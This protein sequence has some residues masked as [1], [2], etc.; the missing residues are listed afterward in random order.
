MTISHSL[1]KDEAIRRLKPAL[2]RA[3]QSFP[4]FKIEHEVWS[5]NRVN[6][7]V[8]AIG[9]VVAGNVQAFDNRVRLEVSLPGCS[10]NLRTRDD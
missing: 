1:G 4:I 5:D 6:F 2:S 3:S 10:Q 8:R 7:Q 9:Q